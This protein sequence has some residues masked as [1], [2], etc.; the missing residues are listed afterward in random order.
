MYRDFPRRPRQ[1]CPDRPLRN[2]EAGR[3]APRTGAVLSGR[4]LTLKELKGIAPSKV[5]YFNDSYF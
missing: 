5:N 2:T 4:I 1:H 3:K